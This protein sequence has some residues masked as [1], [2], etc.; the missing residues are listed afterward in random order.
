MTT[1][2]LETAAQE[3]R[4]EI[5]KLAMR[6]G[7][8]RGTRVPVLQAG[9]G[10]DAV[11]FGHGQIFQRVSFGC[12]GSGKTRLGQPAV[13]PLLSRQKKLKNRSCSLSNSNAFHLEV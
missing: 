10:R 1:E 12:F 9:K 13:G 7:R 5:E 4:E 6:I 3:A 11:G 2:E 8:S